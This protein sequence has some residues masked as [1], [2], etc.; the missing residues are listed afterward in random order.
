M[1]SIDTFFDG[2]RSSLVK[3]AVVGCGC[4]VASEPIAEIVDQWNISQ[5]SIVSHVQHSV[6]SDMIIIHLI[7]IK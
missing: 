4:S 1:R 6:E 2:I 3:I 5:V 7:T